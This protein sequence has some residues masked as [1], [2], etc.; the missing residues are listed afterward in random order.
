M[1]IDL[2]P[3]S[4]L[5]CWQS[6]VLALAIAI[7]THGVKTIIDIKM[8][9]SENR[10]DV[11]W[12]NRVVLPG[13]PLLIGVLLTMLVPLHPEALISYLKDH[14]YVGMRELTILAVYG[15]VL[16]QFSDYVWH[17]FSGVMNDY[18]DRIMSPATS[19]VPPP[20]TDP[21]PT[22]MQVTVSV[23]QPAPSGTPPGPSNT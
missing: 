17:R 23:T 19:T 2:G 12:V 10:Q 18:K 11:I 16:G 7:L 8:G 5:I 6:M 4:I 13:T 3:L 9:G 20:V 21:L 1:D 15:L 14:S 22:P